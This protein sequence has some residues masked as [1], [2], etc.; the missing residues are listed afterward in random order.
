MSE[1]HSLADE[2]RASE[3]ER[4]NQFAGKLTLNFTRSI[5]R[6]APQWVSSSKSELSKH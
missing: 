6:R 1:L 2:K 3:R 4:K 5:F